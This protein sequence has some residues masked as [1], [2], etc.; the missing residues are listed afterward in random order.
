MA[1]LQKVTLT[2]PRDL[3]QD[4]RAKA[5]REGKN[6]SLIVRQLLA[7]YLAGDL[8]LPPAEPEQEAE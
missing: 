3:K 1:D 6:L 2:L 5:I 7:I 4:A 8:T